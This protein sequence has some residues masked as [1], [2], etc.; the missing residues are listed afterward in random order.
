[1]QVFV[2]FEGTT[3]LYHSSCLRELTS[4]LRI[5][6][7]ISSDYYYLLVNGR[8]VYDENQSLNEGDNVQVNIR[9]HGV[10]VKV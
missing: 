6:T 10:G 3:T 8:H 1:M 9:A 4:D 2:K 7:G 5:K